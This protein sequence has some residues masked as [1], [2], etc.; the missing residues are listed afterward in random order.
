MNYLKLIAEKTNQKSLKLT[1]NEKADLQM[2]AIVL[3]FVDEIGS[4]EK[5]RDSLHEFLMK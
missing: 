3:D 4:V 5:L 2:K 1:A